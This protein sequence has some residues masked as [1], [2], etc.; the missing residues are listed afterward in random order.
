MGSTRQQVFE[1]N[2]IKTDVLGVGLVGFQVSSIR[3]FSLY[4]QVGY[5]LESYYI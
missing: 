3:F 1:S 2:S 5:G 4:G